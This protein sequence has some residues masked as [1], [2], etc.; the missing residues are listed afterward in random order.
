MDCATCRENLS[1][2]FEGRLSGELPGMEQ[3]LAQ[4]PLCAHALLGLRRAVG[5][6]QSLPAPEVPAGL[7]ARIAEAVAAQAALRRTPVAPSLG[8]GVRGP[9]YSRRLW[10][11]LAVGLGVAAAFVAGILVSREG[12]APSRSERVALRPGWNPEAPLEPQDPSVAAEPGAEP[13]APEGDGALLPPGTTPGLPPA[14]PNDP[15][16]RLRQNFLEQQQRREQLLQSPGLS[17]GGLSTPYTYLPTQLPPLSYSPPAAYDVPDREPPPR[18]PDIPELRLPAHGASGS[19]ETPALTEPPTEAPDI[20]VRPP[21]GETGRSSPPPTTFGPSDSG[22]AG[23]AT[24]RGTG[25]AA[26]SAVPAARMDFTPPAQPVVG[27][28][29]H[30]QAAITVSSD[31]PRAVVTATGDADLKIPVPGGRVYE[32]PLQAGAVKRIPIPLVASAPGAHELT[33]TLRSDAPG[34]DTTL[35]VQ[36]A[37]FVR[38]AAGAS[39]PAAERTVDIVFNGTPIRRAL[40][41]IARKTGVRITVDES[42]GEERIRKDLRGIPAGAAIRAIADSAGY[43]VDEQ[44]GVFRIYQPQQ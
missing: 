23:G 3:H 5:A 25:S 16:A 31:V 12:D 27:Q 38:A 30:A 28:E 14:D 1:A 7:R 21:R 13:A 26:A 29:A 8:A 10:P 9:R 4:C 20:K 36:V 44:D 2:H 18:L 40:A 43:A 24:G 42:V 6:L 22:P 19:T 11:G 32:G 34:A 41:D 17:G 39:I 35:T 37:G 15:L 33:I